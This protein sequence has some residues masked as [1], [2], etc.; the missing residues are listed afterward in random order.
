MQAH[1]LITGDGQVIT[2]GPI[3]AIFPGP[4]LPNLQART[5]SPAGRE[6]ILAAAKELGL[7]D[8]T[9]D[10]HAGPPLAGGVS[11]RIE[12]TVDGALVTITGDP[13]AVM[14]CVTTPC[15]P[16]AGS[17]AAFAAF[18][19]RL[20]DLGAWMPEALGPEAQYAAGAYAILVGP[21][22]MPDP[23]LPQPPT[24]WPLDQALGLFGRPVGGGSYRCGTVTGDDAARLQPALAK[25]NQLTAWVQD[26]TTS[27]TFGLTVRPMVPGEDVCREVFGP[28]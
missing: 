16:P 25:A 13:N 10:F 11:G 22:P 4:L 14:E 1:V 27:A 23:S 24:D 5:I 20:G 3:P 15:N 26:P 18:W 7:L 17:A 21:A 28:A 2:Q 6:A 9:V 12:L 19:A 8:G